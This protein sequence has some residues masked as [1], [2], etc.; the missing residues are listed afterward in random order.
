MGRQANGSAQGMCWLRLHYSPLSCYA[1]RDRWLSGVERWLSGV[2]RWLSGV[3]RWLS[4]VEASQEDL[5]PLR[6]HTSF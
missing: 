4:G 1:N 3:E 2:E 5:A 6:R